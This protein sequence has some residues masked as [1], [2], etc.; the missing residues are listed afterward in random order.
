MTVIRVKNYIEGGKLIEIKT[1]KPLK[2]RDILK[3][4]STPVEVF[5]IAMSADG[6][7]LNLDDEVSPGSE[8]KLLPSIIGG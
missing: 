5:G 8:I 7:V 4:T 1:D 3:M 2:V 6:G